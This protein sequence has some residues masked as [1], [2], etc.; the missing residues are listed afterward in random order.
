MPEYETVFLESMNLKHFS[1]L[2]GFYWEHFHSGM[3]GA[4][5]LSWALVNKPLPSPPMLLGAL[6]SLSSSYSSRDDLLLNFELCVATVLWFICC[7]IAFIWYF[8]KLFSIY[9]TFTNQLLY[10]W[11]FWNANIR[12]RIK[13]LIR[14]VLSERHRQHGWHCIHIL[15]TKDCLSKCSEW[16]LRQPKA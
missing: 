6:F 1:C 9:S 5:W 2:P 8:G 15:C 10:I 4:I 3:L 14:K 16:D 12:K 13:I 11:L 7:L